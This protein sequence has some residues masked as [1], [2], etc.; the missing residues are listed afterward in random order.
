MNCTLQNNKKVKNTKY[1]KKT[2]CIF[3][4]SMQIIGKSTIWDRAFEIEIDVFYQLWF[5]N[6]FKLQNVKRLFLAQTIFINIK[7][8]CNE[9]KIVL[10]IILLIMMPYYST[11][12]IQNKRDTKNSNKLGVN[13]L[14]LLL[15]KNKWSCF[16]YFCCGL[17]I[18]K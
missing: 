11:Y 3:F 16:R 17:Y 5:G 4:A 9:T 7:Y 1:L 13:Q 2:K 18:T 14:C 10:K 12:C 15:W 6:R 8:V